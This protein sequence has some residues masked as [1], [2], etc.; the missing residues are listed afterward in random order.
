[1]VLRDTS[2]INRDKCGENIHHTMSQLSGD[3]LI[4]VPLSILRA[5]LKANNFYV[6]PHS[7]NE[8]S[9]VHDNINPKSGMQHNLSCSNALDRPEKGLNSLKS[10]INIRAGVEATPTPKGE[11]EKRN[12]PEIP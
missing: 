9:N 11:K 5:C 1:M 3:P 8:K 6:S 2:M 12:H 4:L 10:S 7:S